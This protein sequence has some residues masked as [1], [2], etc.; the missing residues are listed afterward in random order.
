MKPP[1]YH[2]GPSSFKHE[3]PRDQPKKPGTGRGRGQKNKRGTIRPESAPATGSTGADIKKRCD[4]DS[5][6]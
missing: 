3:N 2:K 6:G 4:V 5:A 1:P